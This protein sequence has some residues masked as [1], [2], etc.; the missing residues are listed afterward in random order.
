MGLDKTVMKRVAR[1]TVIAAALT[2]LFFWVVRENWEYSEVQTDPLTSSGLIPLAE[3]DSAVILQEI[4]GEA[5]E[6][7]QIAL[8]PGRMR[9]DASGTVAVELLDGEGQVL[10]RMELEAGQLKYD[11]QNILKLEPAVE[12]CK[13]KPLTIRIDSGKTGVSFQ[14]GKTVTAG[15]IEI[16]AKDTTGLTVQGEP[17]EGKM[18]VATRGRI[19]LGLSWLVWPLAALCYAGCLFLLLKTEHSVRTGRNDF[20]F[21]LAEV[22]KRYGFLL[23]KLVDRDFRTKY[24]ASVL[25]MLWSFLNP[26]LTM[27][28]YLFVFSTL[29]RSNIEHFP[30][31]LMTGIILFNYF[32]DS[33]TLGLASI[34]VN[35]TLIT[36]EYMPKMLYPLAKVLSSAINLMISF[37]P[38]AIVML[39]SGVAFHKSLL[40]LPFVVIFIVLFCLG[41]SLILSTLDVF[42]RDI[43]FLWGVLITIL[44]FLTPI[45]YPETII[46]EAFRTIYHMNPL[47]QVMHFMRCITLDGVAPSPLSFL[48]CFLAGMI[49]LAI[50][51]LVFRKNQDRF[52][53][54]L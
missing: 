32:S 30:V 41:M 25:G 38:L 12:G 16:Q 39:L 53:L 5:D 47:Y 34:V 2:L 4:T 52:V 40:L 18:L 44:N 26:L 33:T 28:V 23:K 8:V 45:F 21:L 27:L 20:F 3:Q 51:V 37:I 22:R 49:P 9:P 17:L 36:K 14:Y 19:R 50:G 1:L 43:Q 31:Y 10:R 7:E 46:P 54:Y 42:F 15:K 35:R 29:F 48:Y 11:E 24:Q 13:G 6:L